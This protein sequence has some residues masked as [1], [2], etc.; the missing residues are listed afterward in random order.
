M[1]ELFAATSDAQI[2]ARFHCMFRLEMYLY[3]YLYFVQGKK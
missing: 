3:T 2:G 1:L